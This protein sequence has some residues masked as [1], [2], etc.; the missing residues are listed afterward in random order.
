MTNPDI[1]R[2]VRNAAFA[3][4]NDVLSSYGETVPRNIL[5]KGFIFKGEQVALMGPQ[6]IFKPRILPEI[7]LSITTAP[8]VPGKSRPY[9]DRQDELGVMI[10]RY[11]GIDPSHH[12]NARLRLAMARGVPLIYFYGVKEGFYRP[13]WPIFVI[14]DH[15]E[16][17][18]FHIM[19]DD[20]LSA[21]KKSEWSPDPQ[22][23][24][25][26]RYI[27][28]E[29]QHRLHQDAFRA[30]VIR[31]Y[32]E[33]CSVCRLRHPELLEAAHIIED[34]YHHG[35]PTVSNGLAMCAIH[36]KAYDQNILGVKPDYSIEIREDVLRETDGPMLRYGLQEFQGKSL[37]IPR[38][39]DERPDREALEE[40]FRKF[41]TAS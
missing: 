40:R 19:V 35:I 25:R 6:G 21:L 31:A 18:S 12:E 3:F 10:Y 11:R 9:D 14:D 4:L 33:S 36:H 26:R 28:V 15:P 5:I 39:S 27:T 1:D 38:R 8:E 41:K 23:I 30:Q 37:L 22:G 16:S 20:A 34:R 2:E 32:R 17:L 24:L 13:I 29:V 7:P